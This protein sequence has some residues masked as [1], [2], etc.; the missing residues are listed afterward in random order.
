MNTA[1]RALKANRV[2]Y[3]NNI[4]DAI[5][6]GVFLT[7][8]VLIVLVSAREWLLLLARKRLAQLRE[9]DPVWLPDYAVAE[10]RPLHALGLIALGL[11]LAK[12]LSGEAHIER[13]RAIVQ[14]P[15][16]DR[17]NHSAQASSDLVSSRHMG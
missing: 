5:V 15:C 14:C 10:G 13:A 7:L 17:E 2:L 11:A 1:Q 4:V 8:V 6:T 3:F 16:E 9:S 12:E